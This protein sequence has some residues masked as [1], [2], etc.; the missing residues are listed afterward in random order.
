MCQLPHA[1]EQKDNLRL[2]K[3]LFYKLSN[4]FFGLTAGVYM[5][6][7]TTIKKQEVLMRLFYN[8]TPLKSVDTNHREFKDDDLV[9]QT[10][11]L[12]LGNGYFGASVFGYPD[13]ERIQITENSFSNPYQRP[14]SVVGDRCRAGVTSFANIYLHFNHRDIENYTR[15]LS[16]D[17]AIC[18]VSY[19]CEGARYHR[20]YFTGYPDR[21]LAVRI[22]S[23]GGRVN[24]TTEIKIPY[25]SDYCHFEGDGL[26]R[27][28]RVWTE[29][30]DLCAE[31]RLSFYNVIGYGR[32]RLKVKGGKIQCGEEN[33]ITVTDAEEAVL[34]FCCGT[35]YR[36]QSRVFLEPTPKEKLSPYPHPK[37][38]IDSVLANASEL[39]YDVL[40]ERHIADYRFLYTRCELNLTP[41]VDIETTDSLVSLSRNGECPSE[42]V[43][44]L[45]SFGRYLLICSS[46]RG[47]L[48]CNLQGIWSNYRTAPW[49]CGYWHNINVQ[50]NYWGSEVCNLAE[51]FLSYSDYNQAYMPLAKKL[52]DE[53]VKKNYPD[54]LSDAGDNGWIIGTGGWPYTID[55]ASGHSGP[56]TGAFTSLLFWDYYEFTADKDYLRNVAYP[57]LRDMSIFFSKSLTYIDGKYLV[58]HSASPEQ[59]NPDG[60]YHITVGCA[61]DQQ[62]VYENYRRTLQAADILGIDEPLLDTIREQIDKLDPVLIG[63]S[64]Q[65]KE[66]RE[67]QYY[68]EIGEYEHRHVSHLVGLY[69]ATHINLDT[70]LWLEGAKV[71]LKERGLGSSGWSIMHRLCLCA[72]IGDSKLADALI[73][74]FVKTCIPDNLWDQ[75]PPFQIDGNLGFIAGAA[76]CLLQSHNGY[77]ELLP[78]LP[79]SWRNGSFKGLVARGGFEI[80]CVF[81]DGKATDATIRSTVGG[82]VNIKM[83][84]ALAATK[85][86]VN[87]LPTNGFV[88]LNTLPGDVIK[89]IF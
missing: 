87:I 69:P 76:E 6:Y 9:W 84:E 23:D 35:N 59:C 40:K 2:P 63:A 43:S 60:S 4:H 20:E 10:Q 52:A 39:G 73:N 50:M 80:D 8:K 1:M 57:V 83:G 21:I 53:Y 79:T 17:D 34:L 78:S 25:I 71:A 3:Y 7:T 16:L 32:V 82:A 67:E 28:G 18:K 44:L 74:K 33:R 68:G 81:K 24:F 86:D 85:N 36:M 29:D 55:G 22:W 31:S 61:F 11:S 58:E 38:E 26:S 65:V 88:T 47:T 46:R 13:D 54:R 49:S 14:P 64:G 30:C 42:L 56:G 15:E 41:T 5:C 66:F 72:R 45:F 89:L 37:A 51:C 77:V 12:P 19:E 27:E 70:P 75:H 48:P 62:M